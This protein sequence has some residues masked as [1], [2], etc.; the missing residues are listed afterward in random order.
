LAF[1]SRF[2]NIMVNKVNPNDVN[3]R[4]LRAPVVELVKGTS[5]APQRSSSYVNPPN[6]IAHKP[7]YASLVFP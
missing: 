1:T 5:C 6:P 2:Q 3:Y 4:I 7:G